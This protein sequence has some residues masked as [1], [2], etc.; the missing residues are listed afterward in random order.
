MATTFDT[1]EPLVKV[2]LKDVIMDSSR[3]QIIPFL[4]HFNT[5]DL[6]DGESKTI[7]IYESDKSTTSSIILEGE[8]AL[9]NDGRIKGVTLTPKRF[10]FKMELSEQFANSTIIEIANYLTQNALNRTDS[11][12]Y[13]EMMFKGYLDATP[14]T[15]KAKKFEIL[16]ESNNGVASTKIKEPLLLSDVSEARRFIRSRKGNMNGAFMLI[17]DS[18]VE[19]S[20]L[21]KAGNEKL[22]FENIPEGADA[23]IM[24]MPVYLSDIVT[25]EG[26]PLPF[27]IVHPEA[28]TLGMGK[29][30]ITETEPDEITTLRG[31]RMFIVES[32][33]DG[34]VTDKYS[35]YAPAFAKDTAPSPWKAQSVV[36][37][38]T[39]PIPVIEKTSS[40]P[41]AE[42]LSVETKVEQPVKKTTKAKIEKK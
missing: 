12:T 35:K 32:W 25:G 17:N 7:P 10:A 40:A 33:R 38:N 31:S 39:D 13:I 14:S 42:A 26:N 8:N 4:K 37:T 22:S 15:E 36:V 20:V 29:L 34:K 19:F 3:I 41:V 16:F 5:V 24:G 21:D 11:G 2:N 23:T 6:S 1:K 28:Y 18:N 9:V 30:T 27:A